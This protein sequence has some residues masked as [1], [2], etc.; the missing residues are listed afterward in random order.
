MLHWRRTHALWF[1]LGDPLSCS[2]LKVLDIVVFKVG[3][4]FCD[5]GEVLSSGR[6]RESN[7]I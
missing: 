2:Q 1:H 4:N 6:R 3:H 7:R 5:K